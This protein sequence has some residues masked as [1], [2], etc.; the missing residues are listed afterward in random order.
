MAMVK[1]QWTR[2]KNEFFATAQPLW[3]REWKLH[4]VINKDLTIHGLDI[5]TKYK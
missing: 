5:E 4:K 2:E 1:E 3:S